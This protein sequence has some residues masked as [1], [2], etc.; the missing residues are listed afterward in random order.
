MV[1]IVKKR[2]ELVFL[3]VM[4][5]GTIHFFRTHWF[6][7]LCEDTAKFRFL[8]FLVF[9]LVHNRDMSTGYK[10]ASIRLV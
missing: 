6:S 1:I 7:F 10:A 8:V 4:I 3:N 2:I 5:M 9:F